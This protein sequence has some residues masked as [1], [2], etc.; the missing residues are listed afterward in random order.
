MLQQ[1]LDDFDDVIGDEFD[2]RK[3]PRTVPYV[4]LPVKPD[5]QPSSQ[6]SFKKN[7]KYLQLVVDFVLDLERKGLISRCKGNEVVFALCATPYACLRERIDFDLCA[8]S[9]T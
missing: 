4:R 5:Y 9:R 2:R 3:Q 7:R 8:P 1:A 6:A